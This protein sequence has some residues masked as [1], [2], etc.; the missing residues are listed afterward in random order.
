MAERILELP[1][2][3]DS[4]VLFDRIRHEP[5]AVFLDSSQGS[6][7]D[8]RYDILACDPF[9]TLTTE[10]RL[11]EIRTR[12]GVTHSAL[13][14]F[15]LLKASMAP[16]ARNDASALPFN[17]GAIGYFSYDLARRLEDLPEQAT[18]AEHLPQMAIGLYDWAVVV[19]HELHQCWLIAQ[20][21]D[22]RTE[23]RW[24]SLCE[25]FTGTDAPV[26]GT[27]RVTSAVVSNLSEAAY[28]HA[29]AQVKQYI[30]AGD[31]YQVNLA[32][33]F[34]ATAE[35]DAWVAYRQL[36]SNSPAPFAAYLNTPAAQILS[37]S[38]E[39]FLQVSGRAVITRPIK[40]TR[41]RGASPEQD[42][43]Y[44]EE[45]Q[46]SLKDRA[47]NL[48]IVDLL[49]NDIGKDCAAG[50]VQVK[51]L[52]ELESFAHV[53]H[54]VSTVT[55][56]LAPGRDAIDLLRDCF[57]GG[58]VTGAPKLR[59]MEIIE[60]LEPHRR[61]VYCGAIAYLA[62]N[63]NMDSNIAIRTAIYADGNIRF[64]AGGGIVA[65]SVM[66]KEYRETWDKA[67]NMLHL[68]E[69]FNVGR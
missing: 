58:S 14:P 21:H 17:G 20:G 5:W 25:L 8:A 42:Q 18:D 46:H 28:A 19:D 23:A 41:P 16:Y 57:P 60:E 43:A 13:D 11:T 48:M 32:Q 50:T 36:R 45:L 24:N 31:C 15:L 39:R 55:G 29:F 35:G 3:A 33:R 67:A 38:P 69:A 2:H 47:E 59:A 66:E 53:H 7:P 51:G 26:A 52:F 9:L 49:R 54:L 64:W 30:Q 22:P 40:G 1:Y 12:T 4:T 6:G 10:G 68:M 44:A 62:F 34:C 37:A 56:T 65:D 63:G 61:G 27:F